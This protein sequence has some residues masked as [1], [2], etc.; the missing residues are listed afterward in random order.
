MDHLA[1]SE[2]KENNENYWNDIQKKTDI[3]ES[4]CAW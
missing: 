4:R 2:H 3:C 1:L